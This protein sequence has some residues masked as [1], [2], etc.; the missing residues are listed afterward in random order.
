[1]ISC[2]SRGS[3]HFFYCQGPP[4]V[5]WRHLTSRL[6]ISTRI[7]AVIA[8]ACLYVQGHVT[9]ACVCLMTYSGYVIKPFPQSP[10][11]SFPSIRGNEITLIADTKDPWAHPPLFCIQIFMIPHFA[12]RLRNHLSLP[13][14]QRQ[15]GGLIFNASS[16]LLLKW[17]DLISQLSI[18]KDIYK[19]H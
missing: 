6:T 11:L 2:I 13:R 15:S 7:I 4:N 1:M 8:H 3:S 9:L 10:L 17:N 14:T 16:L 5:N 19:T 18:L 12:V